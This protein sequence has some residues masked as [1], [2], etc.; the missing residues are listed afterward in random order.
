MWSVDFLSISDN[1]VIIV[2][3]CCWKLCTRCGNDRY[4]KHVQ[5]PFESAL[6]TLQQSVCI[7][8]M[9]RQHLNIGVKPILPL[10]LHSG[11]QQ[12]SCA[13]WNLLERPEFIHVALT[14][15]CDKLSLV[16]TF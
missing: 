8:V 9:Q 13:C 12:D 2:L 6:Q 4:W 15:C 1:M 5:K 3:T 11:K 16:V 14:A 7:Q 10:C